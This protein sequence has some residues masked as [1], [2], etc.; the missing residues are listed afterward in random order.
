MHGSKLLSEHQQATNQQIQESI[1][2]NLCRCTAYYKIIEAFQQ[3][4]QKLSNEE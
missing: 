2:G 4:S 3:A 1:S